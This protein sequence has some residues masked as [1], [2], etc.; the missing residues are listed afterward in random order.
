MRHDVLLTDDA[1]R[2]LAD[3]FDYIAETDSVERAEYVLDRLRETAETL[4]PSPE[5]G[6]IPRELQSLGMREYQQVFFKPYR[7]IYRIFLRRVVIYIIADG[8]R[9]LQ[10]L[11]SQRLLARPLR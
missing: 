2:D 5:R 1:E 8:R 6:Q 4:A 10:L 3:I 7:L 9:D 11:L